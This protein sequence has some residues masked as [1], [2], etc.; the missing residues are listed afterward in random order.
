MFCIKSTKIKSGVLCKKK[1]PNCNHLDSQSNKGS[2][3]VHWLTFKFCVF[4]GNK[5]INL[6]EELKQY[7]H[8]LGPHYMVAP[9][10]LTS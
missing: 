7:F 2:C 6:K 8:G 1:F 9:S 10:P 5:H 4:W 3:Y